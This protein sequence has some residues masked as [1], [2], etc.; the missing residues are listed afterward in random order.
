MANRRF[1]EDG[2]QVKTKFSLFLNLSAVP[3]K[4]TPATKREFILKLTFPLPSP[5]QCFLGS[6]SNELTT[7]S[8][9]SAS[10][11]SGWFIGACP[12]VLCITYVTFVFYVYL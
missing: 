12:Q 4:S 5:R 9:S 3:K 10:G 7:R 1:M 8:A 11:Y 6:Y 2:K